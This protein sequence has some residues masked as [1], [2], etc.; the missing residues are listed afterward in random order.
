LGWA[1]L[2]LGADNT[3]GWARFSTYVAYVFLSP[4][5]LLYHVLRLFVVF[6]E[7]YMFLFFIMNCISGVLVAF[8][9]GMLVGGAVKIAQKL[10]HDRKPPSE[11]RNILSPRTEKTKK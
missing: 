5:F 3:E 11:G 10:R 6:D 4:V 7:S 2:A 1:I 8:M 9:L